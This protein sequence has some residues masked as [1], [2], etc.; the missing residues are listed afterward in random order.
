[1]ASVLILLPDGH[2][3]KLVLP[4]LKTS[5]RE[6][7]LTATMLAALTPA[8]LGFDIEIC[9]ASVSDVPYEGKFDLV[10]ISVITGTAIE[11]YRLADHFRAKGAKVVIGGVHATLLPDEAAAHA[12]AVMT[13]FAE[14]TWPA[15]CRDFL[16]GT[17]KPR[18]DGGSPELAGLPW[19]RRDLQ[20]RFGYMMPQT[21][22][23]TPDLFGRHRPSAE[24][25]SADA[26]AISNRIGN[27]IFGILSA[28]ASSC[29]CCP[30]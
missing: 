7:P 6:A 10:A 19:P 1:M 4:F 9:D 15:M 29:R 20:K 14:E 24:A 16:A 12:D 2:V 18:Y 28:G 3:H 25:E 11:G 17:L 8:E 13:G 30:P 23:A 5:F 22:F 26:N 21:V 27:R